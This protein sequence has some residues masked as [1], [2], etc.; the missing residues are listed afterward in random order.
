MRERGSGRPA[1]G[2]NLCADVPGLGEEPSGC[3]RDGHP[4]LLHLHRRCG[5]LQRGSAHGLARAAQP[6]RCAGRGAAA[7]MA[8]GRPS[9]RPGWGPCPATISEA[10]R[11]CLPAGR[12]P[13]K[14]P[15]ASPV[16]LHPPPPPGPAPRGQG[17]DF[18]GRLQ[19]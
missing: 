5:E 13:Q 11:R 14:P 15:A 8:A 1:H 12:L 4:R 7:D 9:A 19:P 3:C 6:P 2:S 18:P 17:Q 16:E 10:Y